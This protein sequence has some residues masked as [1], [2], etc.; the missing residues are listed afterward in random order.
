MN[1][2]PKH[3]QSPAKFS[4]FDNTCR[5][6]ATAP[7]RVKRIIPNTFQ[8][9][10]L[11]GTDIAYFCLKYQL[12][13]LLCCTGKSADQL[14]YKKRAANRLLHDLRAVYDWE[15]QQSQNTDQIFTAFL[16]G[17][18]IG[19]I[20]TGSWHCCCIHVVLNPFHERECGTVLIRLSR[21]G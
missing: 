9:K 1:S 7:R 11:L 3:K 17:V 15:N 13:M 14:A 19:L 16:T 21:P 18:F 20:F 12:G 4:F 6:I 5:K 8:P 10:S 2:V